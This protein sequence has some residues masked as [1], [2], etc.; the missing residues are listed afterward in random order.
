MKT[1]KPERNSIEGFTL[2]E[3]L[4]VVAII[5]I[6]A[7]LLMPALK[8]A[9]ESARAVQCLNNLK[10]I[11]TAAFIYADD[12]DGRNIECG[13]PHVSSWVICNQ[14][15]TIQHA[16]CK[17]L[18]DLWKIMGQ[19]I[20]VL[21]CPSQR[22]ERAASYPG[23]SPAGPRKYY[24]GYGINPRA[25]AY[26]GAGS[27]YPLNAAVHLSY[28][29]N[30]QNKVWFGDSSWQ[31]YYLKEMW[32][33]TFAPYENTGAAGTTDAQPVSRRH[34]GGSNIL[35]FDGHAAWMHYSALTPPSANGWEPIYKTYWDPD[36]DNL[37]TTP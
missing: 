20:E 33:P 28:V 1:S 16:R 15:V 32:A 11:G 2:I 27:P 14:A 4:V 19:K 25:T 7:A 23:R 18:D 9:R 3:L 37:N 5:S 29:K 24:P 22:F 34:K 17:W 21:E 26:G 8:S 31:T 30:P 6:L 36:E 13:Q 12:N 35:F 10:Q